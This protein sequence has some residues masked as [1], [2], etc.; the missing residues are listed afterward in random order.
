MAGAAFRAEQ[1]IPA[2]APIEVRAFGDAPLGAGP[3]QADRAD[4]RA[5]G[6]VV[7]LQLDAAEGGTSGAP[8]DQIPA[9]VDL[10]ARKP[11]EGRIGD[12]VVGAH[13]ADG[14]IRIEA[15][16]DGVADCSHNRN[17]RERRWASILFS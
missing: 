13:P 3:D 8:V 5:C 4:R 2:V 16:Q 10:H 1:P 9:V 17:Q 7:F 12:V 14:G 6:G 11:L 15:G